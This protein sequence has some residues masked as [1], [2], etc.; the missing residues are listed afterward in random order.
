MGISRL[1][2]RTRLGAGDG[3]EQAAYLESRGAVDRLNVKAMVEQDAL[4]AEPVKLGSSFLGKVQGE[5]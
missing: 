1:I 3:V 2:P 5:I 4:G